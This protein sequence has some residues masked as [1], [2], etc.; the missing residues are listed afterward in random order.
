M[1][2]DPSTPLVTARGAAAR[3]HQ[4]D[5]QASVPARP[6]SARRPRDG[7]Q[8]SGSRPIATPHVPLSV[9]PRSRSGVKLLHEQS[10]G[11]E[12]TSASIVA[13]SRTRRLRHRARLSPVALS[14][15]RTQGSH[16]RP[17]AHSPRRTPHSICRTTSLQIPRG[18]AHDRRLR[19]S[20]GADRSSC[21][22]RRSM[23]TRFVRRVAVASA[24]AERRSAAGGA[25][26][27]GSG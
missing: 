14:K 20:H 27:H 26:P 6:T 22:S 24:E 12:S 2:C 18:H 8:G 1:T 17:P 4:R 21:C 23:R 15:W 10:A 3:R 5:G 9:P 13:V 11:R 25:K 16:S 7:S 19:V